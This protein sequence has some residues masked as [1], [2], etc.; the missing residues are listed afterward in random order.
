MINGRCHYYDAHMRVEAGV[1]IDSLRALSVSPDSRCEGACMHSLRA[2]SV[3]P[4]SRCAFRSL[5]L[6][7]LLFLRGAGN[8]NEL[9]YFPACPHFPAAGRGTQVRFLQF[10]TR[11]DFTTTTSEELDNT[12]TQEERRACV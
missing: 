11:K 5:R 9:P 4:D 6:L 7:L 12:Y 8:S 2:L 1:C 3:S 10:S